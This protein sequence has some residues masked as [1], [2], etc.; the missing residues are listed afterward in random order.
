MVD[1]T[2]TWKIKNTEISWTT[3]LK[4]QYLKGLGQTY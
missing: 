2:I 1:K 4:K 3:I